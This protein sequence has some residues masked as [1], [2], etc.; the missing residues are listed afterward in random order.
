M[1]GFVDVSNMSDQEVKRLGQIDDADDPRD[2]PYSYRNLANRNPWAYR[3]PKAPIVQFS[4]PAEQVWGLAV[5]AFRLNK[6][7]VKALAP[8]LEAHKTNRQVIEENLRNT[9]PILDSDIEEGKKIRQYFQALTFKVIEGKTLTPFLKQAMEIAEREHITSNLALATIASLPATYEKMT[10]RDDVD[11]KIKWATGGYLGNI[12]D[13]VI[14]DIDLV[15]RMWSSNW[16]VWYY[17]GITKNDNVLFFAYKGELEI[18]SCVTIQGTVKG[19][20]DSSTQLNR[21]KVVK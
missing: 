7:Y 17:T 3:K 16:N 5:L 10:K 4:Y 20:R 2:N 8:D 13:K 12:G 15:K 6:G 21:V 18:G 14:E 11:R 1:P 19:H 9:T